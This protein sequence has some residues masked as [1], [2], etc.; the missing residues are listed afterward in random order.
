MCKNCEAKE[1]IIYILKRL[2][3]VNSKVNYALSC[4]N[5]EDDMYCDS[6]SEN[7]FVDDDDDT[8]NNTKEMK[9]LS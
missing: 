7:E 8:E 9:S 5:C 1:V 4:L 6:D 2:N 3:I